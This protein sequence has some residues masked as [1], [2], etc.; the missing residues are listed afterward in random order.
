MPPPP[1]AVVRGQRDGERHARAGARLRAER[2][3]PAEACHAG[4]DAVAQACAEGGLAGVEAGAVVL[5]ADDHGERGRPPRGRSRGS[6]WRA[7]RRWPAP[8]GWPRRGR[9]RRQREGPRPRARRRGGC[10]PRRRACGRRRQPRPARRRGRRARAGLAVDVGA[11]LVRGVGGDAL[12]RGGVGLVG[13]AAGGEVLQRLQDAVVQPGAHLGPLGLA[14]RSAAVGR[15]SGRRRGALRSAL[16]LG[17]PCRTPGKSAGQHQNI[18]SPDGS[19]SPRAIAKATRGRP[20]GRRS[21]PPSGA[22]GDRRSARCRTRRRRAASLSEPLC[23][24]GAVLRTSRSCG[25]LKRRRA[26]PCA[27][28]RG[29]CRPG[30]T[31]GTSV[32]WSPLSVSSGPRVAVDAAALALEQLLAAAGGRRRSVP[33]S[34]AA[35]GRRRASR[36]RR[37]ARRP[38]S[39]SS[40]PAG[41]RRSLKCDRIVPTTKSASVSSWPAQPYG[42]VSATPHSERTS[43]GPRKSPARCG[44]H[45]RAELGV[46]PAAVDVA[47]VW[48][49]SPRFATR[50]SGRAA[51]PRPR[52]AARERGARGGLDGLQDRGRRFVRRDR[53]DA[54]RAGRRRRCR[55]RAGRRARPRRARRRRPRRP[56]QRCRAR[57][58]SPARRSGGGGQGGARRR[59]ARAPSRLR[60]SGLAAWQRANTSA[61]SPAPVA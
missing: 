22:A 45:D 44:M 53:A 10:A 52:G 21:R 43:R 58:A 4:L 47:G 15:W 30:L 41:R 50:S 5:D 31:F 1:F 54:A 37:R 42:G 56:Q 7:W 27:P 13:V 2:R 18:S 26:G 32:S 59:R 39:R 46:G 14:A 60:N 11:Q 33:R 24:Y 38:A 16:V 55:R 12:Q 19:T 9:R 35:R 48:H 40:P 49:D 28:R 6:P 17:L 36:G 29:R 34:N 57:R 61:K 51:G 25:V 3:G 23:M 20:R 8:R